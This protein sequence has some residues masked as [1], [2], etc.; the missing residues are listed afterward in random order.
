MFRNYFKIAVRN[1][2]KNRLYSI[3]NILGLTIGMTCF[4]LIA[5]FIQFELSYDQHFDKADRIHRVYQYQQGNS[6]RGSEYFNVAPKPLAP[7]MRRD[8]PEVETATTIQRDFA[9]LSHEK[10]MFGELGIYGDEHIFE[11]FDFEVLYGDGH[12]AMANPSSI[13]LTE[14]LAAKLFGNTEVVGETVTFG[15][16]KELTVEAIV[17][18]APK[19]QHFDYE[20][21][22]PYSLLSYYQEDGDDS[23]GSNNYKAYVV[24][25][26]GADYKEV[27]KGLSRYNEV[28]DAAYAN[29]PFSTRFFLQPLSDIHL[30]SDL[31]FE[32]GANSDMRYIYLL[33]AIG[34]I[35]LLLASV[36]YM[37]LATARSSRRSREVG[38]RKVLGARRK[39]LVTQLLGESFLVASIGFC[40]AIVCSKLLL[41]A[42]NE[43][44]DK[45][46][47]FDLVGS[48]WLLVTM[49]TSALLVGGLSGLYPAVFMSKVQPAKAFSG[50]ILSS[51]GGVFSLRN[52]LVV[53]QFVTAI[54]LAIGSLVILQQLRFIQDK[55]LGY[56]REQIVYIPTGSE[57]MTAKREVIRSE[58]LNIPEIE[59][60]SYARV[61]PLNSNNQ[62][63]V[64]DWEGNTSG[65][66]L[67]IYRNFV[68]HHFFDLFEMELVEG[69]NFSPEFGRDSSDSYILNET[70]VAALGW[71]SAVGKQY[72]DGTVIGVVKDFHFQ[73][74]DLKIE[75]LQIKYVSEAYG[76]FTFI[77]MKVNSSDIEKTKLAV[78]STMSAMFPK[79]LFVPRLMDDQYDQLYT[80]ERQFGKAFGI[81]TM[82]ALF[83]AGMGLFGLVSHNVIQ[84]TK[85]IG[86][87]K[88]LGA[89]IFSIVEMLSIEFVKL[90]LIALVIGAPVAYYL[91]QRWLQNFSYHTN[92]SWW[93]FGVAGLVA[94]LLAIATTSW[95]SV[96]A[97]MANPVDSLRDE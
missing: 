30:H 11:V 95:Q 67:H 24:L 76:N 3:I 17:A 62:G 56:N 41:P 81:F 10:E 94:I 91:V 50:K 19:N 65:E 40:L 14:S 20:Y 38:M 54:V 6:F 26:D 15:N 9:L 47:P 96:R 49:L 97:A 29:A 88:V 53:G 93:V 13:I 51:K 74:F 27:E 69:R 90:V 63:I 89:S 86:I 46:I 34:F 7:A 58:L 45:E 77:A 31:N 71:E 68:D 2:Q 78:K 82:L 85:E 61:L 32:I 35:I 1:L 37:N 75:P 12:A 48:P 5:L 60:V 55:K 39:Q 64:D 18:D 66:K 79:Q 22:A 57:E 84:R 16:T 8:F 87:R 23:W 25:K 92:V 42:F 83:I 28:I 59:K 52:L 43:L 4:I 21:I 70:A 80:A 44:V 36:N 72:R 33:G 73:P